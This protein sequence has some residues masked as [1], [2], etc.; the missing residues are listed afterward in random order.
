MNEGRRRA[1]GPGGVADEEG[2][3]VM[4]ADVDE[5]AEEDADDADTDAEAPETVR[6]RRGGC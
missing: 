6:W 2:E 1:D 3:P 5:E 4:P